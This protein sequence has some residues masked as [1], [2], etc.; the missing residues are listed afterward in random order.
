MEPA[1]ERGSGMPVVFLHGYPL[2]HGIWQ[3]QLEEFSPHHHVVLLDLPGFGLA[4]DVA[5]PDS[6]IGFAEHV[7]AFLER[8]Q[9]GPAVLVG[10]SF[11]G[12]IA[13][14]LF[15]DHP[16]L[17]RGLVLTDTRALSDTPEAR[18]KRLAQV[19]RLADAN[20]S[21]D[22]EETTRGLLAPSTWERDRPLVERVRTIVKE[23]RAPALRGSLTAMAGRPDLTPVLPTI[24]VPTLVLWGE[25]DHLI[26]PAQTESMVALLQDGA[27]V[28]LSGAGHLPSLEA[29]Q[30]FGAA[31]R[32]FLEQISN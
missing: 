12:Y 5:V 7:R 8:K 31:L 2:H 23:A 16:E 6:L 32:K 29:P 21:L 13:L 15:R 14:Q 4:A 19:R 11:G 27:G 24:S 18:E 3:P 26:P 9:L 17:F 1:L 10:H 25:E 20:Q 28:G 30:A 22:V